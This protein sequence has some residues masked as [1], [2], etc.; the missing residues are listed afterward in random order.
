LAPQLSSRTVAG[1][2][3]HERQPQVGEVHGGDGFGIVCRLI[4][5]LAFQ[6]RE[7]PWTKAVQAFSSWPTMSSVVSW[8]AS[9]VTRPRTHTRPRTGTN[10]LHRMRVM[11]I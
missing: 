5:L 6:E 9:G 7:W 1:A 8:A 3:G 10:P 2:V 11:D 4:K